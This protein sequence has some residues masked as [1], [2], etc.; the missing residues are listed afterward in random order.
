MPEHKKGTPHSLEVI[1]QILNLFD[2][3]MRSK[4]ISLQSKKRI[5]YHIQ[6]STI[7]EILRRNGRNPKD[8]TYRLHRK[9]KIEEDKIIKELGESPPSLRA[10]GESEFI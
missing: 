2:E 10:L 6:E 5:G 4:S 3:G 8:N 1:E 7:S 9:R